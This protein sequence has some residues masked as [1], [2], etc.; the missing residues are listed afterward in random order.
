MW[1]LLWSACGG[2]EGTTPTA[3][4]AGDDDDAVET[5]H[6]GGPTTSTED[7]CAWTGTGPLRPLEGCAAR[8]LTASVTVSDLV[9]EP[10]TVLEAGPGVV[11]R[12]LDSME[13][14]GTVERPIVLRAIDEGA[15]WGGL[16]LSYQP[17]ASSTYYWNYDEQPPDGVT[18]FVLRNVE[19]KDAGAGTPAA[20]TVDGGYTTCGYYGCTEIP[21]TIVARHLAI[22]GSVSGGIAG[23]GALEPDDPVGFADVAGSLVDLRASALDAV[24]V[25]DL[26]G[27][28]HAA[29]RVY[30]VRGDQRWVSQGVPIEVTG[31]VLL[32]WFQGTRSLLRE[33]LVIEANVVLLDADASFTVD[34]GRVEAAGVVFAP[35]SE[36]IPWGG[37]VTLGDHTGYD[38]SA[39][40]GVGYAPSE[41][42]LEGCTVRG[43]RNPAVDWR[44]GH[45]PPTMADTAIGEV[46][47]TGT[48][49][50]VCV[51]ACRAALTDPALDNELTCDVPLACL[52]AP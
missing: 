40:N 7:A 25:E 29:I 4:G 32:R 38:A 28:A 31:D 33:R 22:L 14:A 18:R 35:L 26:G 27:N 19:V 8:T 41:L 12:V 10:D 5:G 9:V 30:A 1:W 6:T 20:I 16:Q 52:P 2:P 45:V 36:G 11:L 15:P 3:D 43:T 13:A 51:A 24:L 47:A 17:D 37:F 34:G 44:G 49:P 50:T 23:D 48:E 46:H 21:S 42:E 39:W